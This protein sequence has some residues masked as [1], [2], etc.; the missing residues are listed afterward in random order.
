[1][2]SDAK[3]LLKEVYNKY[4]LSVR[5]YHKLMKV[6]R[7]IADLENHEIIEFSDIAEAFGYRIT[8]VYDGK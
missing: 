7:T 4:D 3:D 5:A 6:A 8:E 2:E 1:M